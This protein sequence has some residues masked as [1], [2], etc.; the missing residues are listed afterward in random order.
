[1]PFE[2]DAKDAPTPSTEAPQLHGKRKR[3][4]IID[5]YNNGL[6]LATKI[7]RKKPNEPRSF[8]YLNLPYSATLVADN[9]DPD[10]AYMVTYYRSD[11]LADRPY[12]SSKNKETP[13]GIVIHTD[14]NELR[15]VL[16]NPYKKVDGKWVEDESRES[17]WLIR[18]A[19]IATTTENAQ[20]NESKYKNE[21]AKIRKLDPQPDN[22][23]SAVHYLSG[24]QNNILMHYYPGPDL[25]DFIYSKKT[26]I[27][28]RLA[29]TDQIIGQVI[30]LH[31]RG[32]AHRDIKLENF[33]VYYIDDELFVK[34]IDYEFSTE[35]ENLVNAPRKFTPEY[36]PPQLLENK[37][38]KPNVAAD[39][40]AVGAII[41]ILFGWKND[42]IT[43]TIKVYHGDNQE[44]ICEQYTWW[45]TYQSN[46]TKLEPLFD[47]S[48]ELMNY[49]ENVT[50]IDY[51]ATLA[52]I[53]DFNQNIIEN[54]NAFIDFYSAL[55]SN[56][57][58]HAKQFDG[59]SPAD[60]FEEGSC[61]PLDDVSGLSSN[62]RTHSQSESKEESDDLPHNK[63]PK[64][65]F[66]PQV[67]ENTSGLTFNG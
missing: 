67:K 46:N 66:A 45:G 61:E 32:E 35:F 23:V 12:Y 63:I 13:G 40:W 56:E 55:K 60:S 34:L 24:E 3:Q 52:E 22:Q 57:K 15:L 33:I 47:L 49:A 17:E 39:W 26:S 6:A 59:A 30:D 64:T 65:E 50:V 10:L 51:T 9:I 38:S 36:T 58:N 25:F 5:L 8:D 44:A 18:K 11:D 29:I 42:D 14:K 2:K 1:M 41:N 16:V 28:E 31:A 21:A 53:S 7:G 37:N 54:W 43:R 27:E 4:E 20:K 19:E 62:K 48:H